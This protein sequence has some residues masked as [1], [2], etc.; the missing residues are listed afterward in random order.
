[1]ASS[2]EA[3]RQFSRWKNSRTVLNFTVFAKEGTVLNI[4]TGRIISVE[5]DA[6]AIGVVNDVTRDGDR[7]DFRG[8]TFTLEVGT[9]D[10]SRNDLG[11][12]R[13]EEKLVM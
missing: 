12:F 9:I 13:F 8:A 2:N 11:M 4:C 5:P 10:V 6:L 1:M 7:L 3:F